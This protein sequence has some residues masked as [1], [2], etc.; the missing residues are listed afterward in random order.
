MLHIYY[1]IMLMAVYSIRQY[2]L[3]IYAYFITI[4]NV[5]DIFFY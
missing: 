3:D 1:I 5:T 2:V 4:K